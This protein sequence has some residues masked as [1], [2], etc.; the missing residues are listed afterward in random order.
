M[1]SEMV[2]VVA[3]FNSNEKRDV[4]PPFSTAEPDEFSEF[5]YKLPRLVPVDAA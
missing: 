4:D 5:S 1:A 3:N 2:G